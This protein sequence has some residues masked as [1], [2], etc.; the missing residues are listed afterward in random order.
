M[1][2]PKKLTTRELC[3]IGVFAI[4]IAACAQIA[5]PQPGG[6]PFTLQVWAVSLAGIVLG[7]K[8]G[9]IATLVY[10]LLGAVGAPVFSRFTGGFG[11]ILGPTGGFILTFPILAALA[12]IGQTLGNKQAE[13][14]AE[15]KPSTGLAAKRKATTGNTSIEN[16][17]SGKTTIIWMMLGLMA[18][19]II[20]LSAG[21]I[22]FRIVTGNTPA[23]SFSMAV[24]PFIPVTIAQIALVPFIGKRINTA[25]R[26][27][28][29]AK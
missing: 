26:K 4:I 27:A 24:L 1:Q 20:N 13:K 16:A 23:A 29:L 7:L 10:I 19:N 15:E 11:I 14:T 22:W 6:V 21:L 2:K 8:N 9:V 28:A 12:A 5:I 17:D 18:G 3:Y 25:M